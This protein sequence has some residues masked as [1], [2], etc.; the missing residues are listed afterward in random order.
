MNRSVTGNP[1]VVVV[2]GASAGV[3]R[4]VAHAFARRGATVGLI[5]R[6][7]AGLEEAADEVGQLGGTGIVLPADVADHDQVD[8]AGA[9]GALL[10]LRA[11]RR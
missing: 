3:G 6:G 2:T 8:A 9:G 1:R 5:A 11:L 10:A 4:A 7:P